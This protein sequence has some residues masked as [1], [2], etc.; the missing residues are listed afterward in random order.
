MM[1][2]GRQVS[3]THVAQSVRKSAKTQRWDHVTGTLLSSIPPPNPT[4]AVSNLWPVLQQP[5]HSSPAALLL[6]QESCRCVTRLTENV[7]I[8]SAG[9]FP[10]H[11]R[12]HTRTQP[13]S[14]L[15]FPRDRR[16][17]RCGLVWTHATA[18]TA[19][20]THKHTQILGQTCVCVRLPR[21]HT[22]ARTNPFARS[23]TP[24]WGTCSGESVNCV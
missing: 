4:P 23:D 3:V 19:T 10:Y 18:C 20:V 5:S 21:L 14:S 2:C 8:M 16:L 17:Q 6:R 22:P 24:A 7:S 12:A 15:S 13:P 11:T 9:R 1:R